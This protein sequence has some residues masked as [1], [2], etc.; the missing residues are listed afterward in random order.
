MAN[1][2]IYSVFERMW[3]HVL[4]RFNNYV[5]TEVLD[6]HTS[7]MENPH[8]VTKEQIGL[9]NVDD[10]ADLD[11]P[12]SY[13][14]QAVL[15][16]KADLDHTHT[17]DD[18]IGLEDTTIYIQPDEPIDAEDGALWIDMDSDGSINNGSTVV[19]FG[20]AVNFTMVS[21]G[22][23]NVEL[24]ADKDLQDIVDAI[25]SGKYIVGILHDAERTYYMQL[26]VCITDDDTTQISFTNWWFVG[27]EVFMREIWWNALNPAPG[28]ELKK[29]SVT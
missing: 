2:S 9:A 18:I 22:G 11:K 28:Y 20:Y 3:Q 25:Q 29:I 15:D 14:T 19:S 16:G 23:T 24:R 27:D 7:N 13:A 8:D 10:T 17:K 5:P 4:A 6:N 26:S 1:P 12:I 21:D